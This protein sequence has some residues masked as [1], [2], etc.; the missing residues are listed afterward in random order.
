MASSS[1]FELRHRRPQSTAEPSDP[2]DLTPQQRKSANGEPSMEIG[3]GIPFIV[4]ILTRIVS[5]RSNL[6][7]DCD[8]TFNYW[9]PLHYLLYKSG[10]QTWE[11]SSEF[12]LRSYLYILLH[13]LAAAPASWWFGVEQKVRVF[14]F[15]RLIL[16]LASTIS[17]T[18]LIV[19]VSS[20]YGRRLAISTLLL[21]AFTSGC[22]IAST[23]FLPSTFSMYAITLASAALL[24]ERPALS[25]SVAAIGVLLG[26]PFSILTAVPLVIYALSTGN[27]KRVFWS[28]AISSIGVMALS[29]LT[30]YY[31]YGR[32][33]SSVLNLLLYNVAGG[34]GSHLYGVEGPL[35]YLRNGFNNFNFALVFALL[36]FPIML[37]TKKKDSLPLIVVV[38]PVY[39]WLTFMSLQPH[40]EERFLYPIY[41]LICLAAASVIE[42]FPDLVQRFQAVYEESILVQVAKVLRPLTL[43]IILAIC[44]SRTNALLYGYSAPMDVYK[45]LAGLRNVPNES[46][47]CV[48]SEW[49]RFPSSFFLHANV[50]EVQWI[51]DGFRGLLPI[52]FNETLGGTA[53]APSYFNNRNKASD[54][55]YLVDLRTC[56]FLVELDV[57]RGHI[58]RGSDSSMWETIFELPF[59]DK[60][61]SPILYRG[62]AIP[63]A[64]ESRNVF[65]TYRLLKKKPYLSDES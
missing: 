7:H 58:S 18:A 29:V 54:K 38:S 5:A 28:G 46:V 34:G 24:F 42:R 33:T 20:K 31:Y 59:L 10:L 12:S 53:S 22:F 25:V 21:L 13:A 9:E 65:G 37:I 48:G 4:L 35:F 19:A 6:I 26:W 44:H 52:P 27:F 16:G 30:D 45:H 17:E 3:W 39:L 40:K 55:Q 41:P 8:E 60:D 57:K 50:S 1:S 43:G 23:S 64:W 47:L 51:N 61:R 63:G 36:F 32:W 62:F 15:L 11:Y 2:D 56:N 14:Y 49:H